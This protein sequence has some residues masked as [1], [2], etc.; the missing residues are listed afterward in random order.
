MRFFYF[1]VILFLICCNQRKNNLP[2]NKTITSKVYPKNELRCNYEVQ[3]KICRQLHAAYKKQP[4]PESEK[5]FL[6]FVRD[7]LLPCWYGTLWGFYGTTEEPGTG[8]IACGYFV[9][10]VLRD[11]GIQLQRI[12]LAQCASEEMIESVCDHKSIN[13]FSNVDLQKFVDKIK[14][15]PSGLYIVGLDNHTGFILNDGQEV[16]F[17]HSTYVGKGAVI[18]ERARESIVLASSK[19]RVIGKV[20][21]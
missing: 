3:E 21:L 11:I 14:E 8:K 18:S 9:T 4:S 17:I 6:L 12:K 19:Y 15:W 20:A 13:R 16:Y 1:A 7:S 2:E 10:T 5:R